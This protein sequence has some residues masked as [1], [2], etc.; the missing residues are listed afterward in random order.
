M[1]IYIQ[2]VEPVWQQIATKD[3][4]D[5]EEYSLDSYNVS[6]LAIKGNNK[7]NGLIRT[8]SCTFPQWKE[9]IRESIRNII[10]E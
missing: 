7:I 5:I 2:K 10:K 8:I 3:S 6:Y 1:K 9:E 4:S